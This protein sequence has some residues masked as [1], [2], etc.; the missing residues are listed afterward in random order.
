MPRKR[1][2]MNDYLDIDVVIKQ[3]NPGAYSVRVASDEGEGSCT[4]TL[5]FTLA[6]LSGAVFGVAESAR[7]IGSVTPKESA[8][9][10]RSA[11]DFGVALFEALFQ[12]EAREVVTRTLRRAD[13]DT[14]VLIRLRMDL[15]DDGI[16]EVA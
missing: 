4:L 16:A 12:G 1:D 2:H 7:A 14:T 5:P 11:A 13:R 6:D 3:K 9:D 10:A 15:Q 8:K